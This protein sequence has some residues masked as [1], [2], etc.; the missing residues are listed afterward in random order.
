MPL[1]NVISGRVAQCK[2]KAKHSGERCKNLCVAGSP[3]CR[4]HGFHKKVARLF[5]KNNPN[6]KHG[7]ETY[8]ELEKRRANS[9]MFQRLEEIGWHIGMFTGTKTRGRKV[10]VRLNLEN[11]DELQ[12]AIDESIRQNNKSVKDNKL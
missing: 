5:G 1:P 8:T 6:F 9:L 4:M 2:A 7:E 11:S 10:G 12:Q 3:V